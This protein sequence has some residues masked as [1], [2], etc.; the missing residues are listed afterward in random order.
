MPTMFGAIFMLAR[1]TG[2]LGR[3]I[4]T[5]ARNDPVSEQLANEVA[6]NIKALDKFIGGDGFACCDRITLAD[7]AL[8]PGLFFV[9][10]VMPAVGIGSPISALAN[11]AAYWTE[12]QKNE[13]AARVL[14]ELHRGLEERRE[15]IRSGESER[16]RAA[17]TA[18]QREADAQD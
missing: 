9:E 17:R 2:A 15:K 13:H 16:F 1:Q 4:P 11:V 5:L 6:R 7:C 10:I 18:A 3:R 12:V 14:I 8:V